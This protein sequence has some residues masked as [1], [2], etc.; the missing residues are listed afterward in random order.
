MRRRDDA[1]SSEAPKLHPFSLRFKDSQFEK[2]FI[3]TRISR[4]MLDSVAYMTI[5]LLAYIGFFAL[6]FLILSGEELKAVVE[7]R[8]G[9]CFVLLLLVFS[10]CFA[11]FR[12]R[13]QF[14]QTTVLLVSGI[15]IIAMTALLSEPARHLYYAGIILVIVY[16]TN[17]TIRRFIYSLAATVT[18]LI[19]YVIVAVF[20]APIQPWALINNLFFLTVAVIFSLWASYTSEFYIR[21]EFAHQYNLIKEKEKSDRL[22]VAAEAGNHAKSEFLAVMSHELRTPL[23]AIIGFSEVIQK[24]M[25][26]PLGSD[27]YKSYIDDI[28]SSGHHLLSIINAILDLSKAD[29]GKLELRETEVALSE[30]V[31]KGVNSFRG[32]A[33]NKHIKLKFEPYK[34]DFE[35]CVDERL[36]Q[37]MLSNLISNALKFTEDGGT[38]WVDFGPGDE[39]SIEIVVRDNGIGI[40][41]ED[42]PRV[43]EPFIQ[44]E[45]SLVRTN[46]GTGLG[47]PLVK[48]MIELHGGEL[49]LSS[50]LEEGTTAKLIVPAERVIRGLVHGASNSENAFA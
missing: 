28:S 1:L 5:G 8:I 48:R 15:G 2:L 21:S 6:D 11:W 4:E 43:V 7:L 27:R 37:Q 23:N 19:V 39:G 42:L 45:N 50:A 38:V 9:I 35:V 13:V 30:L 12:E 41:S 25:F 18:I 46:E 44:S 24:E 3:L 32:M 16:T 20:V 34:E 33:E 36:F 22:L 47:L 29:A 31:Q 10:H 14:V 40:S 17:F 26:G 49:K